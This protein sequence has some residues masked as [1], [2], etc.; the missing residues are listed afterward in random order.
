MLMSYLSIGDRYVF[1]IV[2][3]NIDDIFTRVNV[4]GSF[5]SDGFRR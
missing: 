2:I 4:G 5:F 3:G 1:V